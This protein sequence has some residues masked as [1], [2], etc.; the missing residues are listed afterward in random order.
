MSSE[1]VSILFVCGSLPCESQ[2][3]NHL[4]RNFDAMSSMLQLK[5]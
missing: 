2:H 1:D 5:A 3:E 4:T